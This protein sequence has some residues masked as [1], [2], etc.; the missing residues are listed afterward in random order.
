MIEMNCEN[1]GKNFIRRKFVRVPLCLKCLSNRKYQSK[2]VRKKMAERN[3]QIMLS[4]AKG[5]TQ[6]EIARELGISNQAVSQIVI[7]LTKR[8]TEL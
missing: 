3:N 1:C 7:R 2:G 5:K 4:K 8:K 6:S